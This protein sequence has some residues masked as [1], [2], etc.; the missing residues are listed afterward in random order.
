MVPTERPVRGVGDAPRFPASWAD[1]SAAI[2]SHET[3]LVSTVS[4]VGEPHVVPVLGL[5]IDERFYFN[6]AAT[7]WKARNLVSNR[8]IAASAVCEDA[9]FIVRRS[10]SPV[11]DVPR[12]ELVAQSFSRKYNWWHPQ[13]RDGRFFAAE[14]NDPR[15]VF[16]V[17]PDFVL[18]FGRRSGLTASRWDF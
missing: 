6:S 17:R 7:A 14:S 18:A 2:G 3:Y 4:P 11:V 12:L 10:A 9:D 13:V 8:R 15:T 1:V 16:E 5:W